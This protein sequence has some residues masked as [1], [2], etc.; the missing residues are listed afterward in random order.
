[1]I[2]VTL[3]RDWGTLAAVISTATLVAYLTG[4]TTVIALRAQYI[5]NE[6]N[7]NDNGAITFKIFALN[8]RVIVGPIFLN[9]I[10]VVG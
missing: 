7:T 3:F 1:M 4:P 8:G 5:A 6:A 9:A 10:T 2:M